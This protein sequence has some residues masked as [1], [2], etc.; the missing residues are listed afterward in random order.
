MSNDVR[1]SEWLRLKDLE[2]YHANVRRCKCHGWIMES[3]P[4]YKWHRSLY[5]EAR[6][7]YCKSMDM[8]ISAW[9]RYV[10]PPKHFRQP[11]EET[12]DTCQYV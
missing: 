9:E 4:N 8:G 3:C 7:I 1:R 10:S 6:Y 12:T 5:L 2:R 11:R